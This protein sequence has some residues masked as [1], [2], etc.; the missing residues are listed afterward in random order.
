[1][2]SRKSS[3]L[4]KVSVVLIILSGIIISYSSFNLYNVWVD[5]RQASE[6]RIIED[7]TAH[8]SQGLKNFMFER[9]RTNVVLAREDEICLNN[10]EFID[11]RR[12]AADEGFTLGFKSIEKKYPE[13]SI[14]LMKEYEEIEALRA[15][16]DAELAK[17]L[18][19]RDLSIRE[20]WFNRC[21]DYVSI[22]IQ[23]LEVI[24]GITHR[25]YIIDNYYRFIL[26]SW[27]FRNIVGLEATIFTSAIT[28]GILTAG[29]YEQFLQL[30]GESR[31]IWADLET[32]VRIIESSELNKALE[33]VREKYYLEYR[34]EQD[35]LLEMALS[36]EIYEGAYEEIASLSVTALDSVFI[37]GQQAASEITR[38]ING[39]IDRALRVFIIS[40]VLL[41]LTILVIIIGPIYLSRNFVAPLNNLILRLDEI[42][43]GESVDSV[44]YSDRK[45]EIGKLASGVKI[46]QQTMTAEQKLKEELKNKVILLEEISTRDSL[47]GLYNRRFTRERME[48]LESLYK[49]NKT[50]FS[51]IMCDID[52]FKDIN[53]SYGHGCGDKVLVEISRILSGLG[54]DYDILARWGGEEFLFVLPETDGE[55]ALAMAE[56]V[57]ILVEDSTV[58]YEEHEIKTT[59][60]FGVSEYN[61]E[62]IHTTIRNADRA[63]YSGKRNGRNQVV[64]Y[65]EEL[66]EGD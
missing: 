55:S 56:R 39:I 12:T 2:K 40:L 16:V 36:N 22:V 51:V 29:D 6:L 57:R 13:I 46:L 11:Q 54:R 20:I 4:T 45:D 59:M 26:D 44:T 63:L 9:G 25:D 37:A 1:M 7:V 62:G 10:R 58:T 8:F 43:S 33:N 50:V 61:E 21:T 18:D 3:I 34:P 66:S 52:Y 47:T 19:E 15:L 53:D 32:E 30:R 38:E 49:R 24:G 17:P 23:N 41:L 42:R 35:K 65:E 60:T 31:R 48:D 27:N 28:D 64:L 14:I 5:Y